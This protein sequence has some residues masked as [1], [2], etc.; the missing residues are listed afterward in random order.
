MLI[1]KSLS[2]TFWKKVGFFKKH[3]NCAIKNV[4]FHLDVGETM[5]VVGE[6]GCGK[7]TLGRCLVRLIEPDVGEVLY[8]GENILSFSKKQLHAF[9]QHVQMVF[10]DPMGSLN[11]R[12][13]IKSIVEEGLL[14]HKNFTK[15]EK[16]AKVRKIFDDVGL[17]LESLGRF[18]HEFSGGQRQRISIARAL[19]NDPRW[20]VADE[21]VSAL[22]VSIQ[23]Q[24]IQL[25]KRL[26]KQNNLSMIFISH[27]LRVVHYICDKIM[28]M[29]MGEVVEQ[30]QAVSLE[31]SLH[32]YT[33]YL[34]TCVPNI[35][36]SKTK[37]QHYVQ[38]DKA[39]NVNQACV[40]R[41]RCPL[42]KNECFEKKP[43]LK[44]IKENHWLACHLV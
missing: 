16:D 2:K 31:S 28:V 19:I 1:V 26:Q 21:P 29:Y 12:M 44:K 15:N 3:G 20:L 18:P 4:S 36:E 38:E 24:I 11:P 5:G 9:R 43:Q 6:S 34:L 17:S 13:K 41:K 32:P 8:N 35:D 30:I 40:Y 14:I 25:L 42:S 37:P 22:D 33:Q 7:T 23:A 10:Q 39:K 27:D